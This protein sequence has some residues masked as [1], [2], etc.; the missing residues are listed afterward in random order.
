MLGLVCTVDLFPVPSNE[1]PSD[2][3]RH[4]SVSSGSASGSST[5]YSDND[6]GRGSQGFPANL[7]SAAS[8][9]SGDVNPDGECLSLVRGGA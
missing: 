6:G 5:P 9:S 8:F 7:L 3:S 2:R 1:R 4:G